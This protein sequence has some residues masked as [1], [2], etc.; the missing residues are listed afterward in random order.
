MTDH[1]LIVLGL[2]GIG[3]AVAY[4]A[5]RRLGDTVLG[6]EQY[7][8]GHLNGGSE[9]HSRIIR[10]SYHTPGYVELAKAAF[11]AWEQVEVESG[12]QL[13]LRTGGLDMAPAN[14]SIGL[15]DYRSS[16]TSANVAFEE[17][18]AS[19]VMRR[20]PQWRLGDDVTALYQDR[21]GIV[22]AS[23]ANA[24]HRRLAHEQGAT[25]IEGAEVS[26][27]RDIGGEVEVVAGGVSYRSEKLVIAAG[28]WTNRLLA[29]LGFELPLEVTQ[30]QVV[31]LKPN[32]AASFLPN[33][34]PIWIWMDVPSFY[35]FPIFGEPAVKVAWDRCEIVTDPEHRSFE[36]RSDVNEAIRGFVAKHLPGADGDIHLA[37]TCLYT[38]TPDRDFVVDRVPGHERILTA[39][40]AGHAFKFASLLGR[41]LSDL[42]ID[43][44]TDVDL[45]P[46]AADRAILTEA[47]PH[48]SYM[49]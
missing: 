1:K 9:D 37:K 18:T 32:D 4:W 12:E 23:R 6:I 43:G 31:Y 25:M 13:V 26:A 27:I 49:V 20:W 14:A 2:G 47:T 39:V 28:A 36:P 34:F 5:S 33:R 42:A 11:L 29:H 22:M 30:E 21:S 35:G 7:E 45:T 48:R 46:F 40:G 8:M 41:V 17:L 24:T 38:L 3:S 44:V 19:E 16:M 15:D 10:L